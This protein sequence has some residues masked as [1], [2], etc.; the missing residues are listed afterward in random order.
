M[1]QEAQ[2]RK[3]AT[4]YGL[5]ETGFTESFMREMA[6]QLKQDFEKKLGKPNCVDNYGFNLIVGIDSLQLT[7]NEGRVIAKVAIADSW[8]DPWIENER[9]RHISCS[10]KSN[11][12]E[13]PLKIHQSDVTNEKIEFEWSD[14]FPKEDFLEMI[15]P[16]LTWARSDSTAKFDLEI[17]LD[18]YP[19]FTY[20]FQF[21]ES[22]T[23]KELKT[24]NQF[25]R[26]HQ[27]NN[28]TFLYVELTNY[29][30]DPRFS[31]GISLQI[32]EREKELY[33]SKITEIL[34]ELSSVLTYDNIQKIR[35]M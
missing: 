33:L 26:D 14:D 22:P 34:R 11:D 27:S 17:Y 28:P 24:I 30:D 20:E 23:K 29:V 25:F 32:P 8:G 31:M 13:Q 5:E 4:F 10:W 6:I 2:M 7:E 3:W 12:F 21:V 15:T 16:S 9:T 19:P 35:I 1:S 18:V